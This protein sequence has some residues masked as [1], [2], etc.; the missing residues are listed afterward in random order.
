MNVAR[1]DVFEV[2]AVVPVWEDVAVV[3]GKPALDAIN[4]LSSLGV[5]IFGDDLDDVSLMKT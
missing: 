5:F 3:A 4:L 1:C 2:G